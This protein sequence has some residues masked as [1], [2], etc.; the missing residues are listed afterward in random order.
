M[1]DGSPPK[2][3]SI[4]V[5]SAGLAKACLRQFQAQPMTSGPAP[6]ALDCAATAAA[7][8]PS[9]HLNAHLPVHGCATK[10]L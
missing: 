2:A 6:P 3:A 9:P 4:H 8:T 10:I 1:E 5:S 7:F